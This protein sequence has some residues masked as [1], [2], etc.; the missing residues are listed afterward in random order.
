MVALTTEQYQNIIRSVK[1]GIAGLRANPRVAAV[2]TA[3]AN[4]G[5]RVGDILRLRLCDIIKDGGRYRLNM[6]EEKTGKKR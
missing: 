4:L 5:M 6:R 3:E 2:L 1:T